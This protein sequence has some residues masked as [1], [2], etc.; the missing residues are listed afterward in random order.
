M[1]HSSIK[2]LGVLQFV[3]KVIFVLQ[4]DSY[5]IGEGKILKVNVSEPKTRL[6]IGNIPKSKGKD[7]I[8]EEFQKLSGK[9]FIHCPSTAIQTCNLMPSLHFLPGDLTC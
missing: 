4:L 3:L 5:E 7:E 8:E 2:Y 6:F 1:H 9:I